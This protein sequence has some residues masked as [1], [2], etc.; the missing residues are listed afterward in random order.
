MILGRRGG[1][2]ER[3]TPVGWRVEGG[4]AG[5]LGGPGVSPNGPASLGVRPTMGAFTCTQHRHLYLHPTL[6]LNTHAFTCTQ[7]PKALRG[8]AHNGGVSRVLSAG[9]GCLGLDVA[10]S[11]KFSDKQALIRELLERLSLSLPPSLSL[12]LSLSHT[13]SLSPSL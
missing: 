10:L 7:H 2:Y 5:A 13:F 6:A 1:G 4:G 11:R 8:E 3:G 9:R 12:S